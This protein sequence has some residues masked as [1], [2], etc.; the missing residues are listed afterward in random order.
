MCSYYSDP[1]DTRTLDAHHD[2]HLHDYATYTHTR[3]KRLNE[4]SNA[5]PEKFR[6]HLAA[7]HGINPDHHHAKR[8]YHWLLQ[9]SAVDFTLYSQPWL[10]KHLV[11]RCQ[12]LSFQTLPTYIDHLINSDHTEAPEW[13]HLEKQ[14]FPH[15]H[16]SLEHFINTLTDIDQLYPILE[17]SLP[18]QRLQT[19]LNQRIWIPW[20]SSGLSAHALSLLPQL[21]QT[22]APTNT[23]DNTN[24]NTD[25][26]S[27]NTIRIYA[28]D[29]SPIRLKRANRPLPNEWVDEALALPLK[30]ITLT[31][32]TLQPLH[33]KPIL[34]A[35]L[36]PFVSQPYSEMDLV[37]CEDDLSKYTTQARKRI[38][39]LFHY[40]LKEG[41]ILW[42]R[43]QNAPLHPP[44]FFST[45]SKRFH[46]FRNSRSNKHTLQTMQP[47]PIATPNEREYYTPL[48]SNL[49]HY[50]KDFSLSDY[51]YALDQLFDKSMPPTILFN[52]QGDVIHLFGKVGP[53][54]KPLTNGPFSNKLAPMLIPPLN[55]LLPTKI[56]ALFNQKKSL[57]ITLPKSPVEPSTEPSTDLT[58][59]APEHLKKV[60]LIYLCHAEPSQSC[61][62]MVFRL[63]AP[64]SDPHEKKIEHDQ[65][66]YLKN[67]IAFL[68]HEIEQLQQINQET[69]QQNQTLQ[70]VNGALSQRYEKMLETTYNIT[71]TTDRSPPDK[72]RE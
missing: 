66:A 22:D 23:D 41:G 39:S 42:L 24:N 40:S 3:H 59:A 20:C 52:R 34:F 16:I 21:S 69:L 26:K 45:L 37:I 65:I 64:S 46:L 36:N 27:L 25:E 53:F 50:H 15:N 31:D 38:F 72:A 71:N 35:Q 11:I 2:A 60:H 5:Q 10:L 7:Q 56:E 68:E 1:Y 57:L 48:L 8:L 30:N 14:L 47:Q 6:E 29:I 62:A 18:E 58:I 61:G 43:N 54:V 70:E 67:K 19:Q 55:S 28:T 44:S 33:Q 9:K 13:S 49:M 4:Y 17:P 32:V 51:Q 12:A 63:E